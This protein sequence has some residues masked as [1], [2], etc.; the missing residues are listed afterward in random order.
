MYILIIKYNYLIYNKLKK[1]V[2]IIL[3][4]KNV[5]LFIII[6]LIIWYNLYVKKFY[7]NFGNVSNVKGVNVYEFE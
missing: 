3:Q 4:S 2:C 6:E 7:Y 1:I 5:N